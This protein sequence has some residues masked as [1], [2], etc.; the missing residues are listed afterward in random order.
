MELWVIFGFCCYILGVWLETDDLMVR[1]VVV[2]V[3]VVVVVGE[4]I[5]VVESGGHRGQASS[6]KTN[7]IYMVGADV[8]ISSGPIDFDICRSLL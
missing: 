5:S 8:E 4:V 2:V 3:V 7:D 6:T 1:A